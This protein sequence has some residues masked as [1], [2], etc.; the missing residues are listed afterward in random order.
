MQ[1]MTDD[2]KSHAAGNLSC[3]AIAP[4]TTSVGSAGTGN[5]AWSINTLITTRISPYSPISEMS[6]WVT[7]RLPERVRYRGETP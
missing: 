5:P 4:A 1:A 3:A 6:C 2:K 7:V